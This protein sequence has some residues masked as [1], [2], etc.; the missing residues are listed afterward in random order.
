MFDIYRIYDILLLKTVP[1][2]A[3]VPIITGMFRDLR[4]FIASIGCTTE[5]LVRGP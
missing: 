2:C 1:S 4:V 3:L 5:M